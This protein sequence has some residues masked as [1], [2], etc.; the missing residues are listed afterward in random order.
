MTDDKTIRRSMRLAAKKRHSRRKGD[1]MSVGEAMGVTP[2]RGKAT[3]LS[4]ARALQNGRAAAAERDEHR[5]AGR[6]GKGRGAKTRRSRSDSLP[7]RAKPARPAK[8]YKRN[9]RAKSVSGTPRR[10]SQVRN[11]LEARK[12]TEDVFAAGMR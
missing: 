11:S 2:S 8:P 9:K 7:P 4:E 5:S 12:L 10:A 3:N 6:K 1:R